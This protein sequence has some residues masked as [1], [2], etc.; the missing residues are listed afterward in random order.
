[1]HSFNVHFAQAQTHNDNQVQLR[2]GFI[3][4][5]HIKTPI[6]ARILISKDRLA[7]FTKC[8]QLGIRH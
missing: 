8:N 4:A 5:L 6:C 2:A 1:M 3:E 7:D